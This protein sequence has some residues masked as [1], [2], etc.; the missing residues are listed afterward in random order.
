[1]GAMQAYPHPAISLPAI[2]VDDSACDVDDLAVCGGVEVTVPAGEQW[3]ALV[4]RAVADE[5]VGVEA[6]SGIP[7]TVADAVRRN[8]SRFG[9]SVADVVT[10]VRT[11]D[12]RRDAQRTFAAVDCRFA[13]GTSRF[14]E[15]DA[16]A[17]RYEILDVVFLFRQGDLTRPLADADLSG[18]LGVGLGERVRL[19]TVR[20]AVTRGDA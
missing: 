8:A 2:V 5:W 20:D 12:R 6:L 4:S 16:G 14:A 7:G 10:S 11:W 19:E 3:D 18:V 17:P 15:G 9:A 1:M 13:E